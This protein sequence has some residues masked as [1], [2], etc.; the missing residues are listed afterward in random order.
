MNK[1]IRTKGSMSRNI[2]R[3]NKNGSYKLS[4]RVARTEAFLDGL[5]HEVSELV[6]SIKSLNMMMAEQAE[7]TDKKFDELSNK[8]SNIGR[9]PG[10]TLAAWAAVILAVVGLAGNGYVRDQQRLESDLKNTKEIVLQNAKAV[11]EAGRDVESAKRSIKE[12]DTKLQREVSLVNA[13]TKTEI[14]SLDEKLQIEMVGANEKLLT[15]ME[16]VK[17]ELK[18]SR[19]WRSAHDIRVRGLNESQNERLTVLERAVFKEHTDR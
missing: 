18:E 15:E 7:R 4:E 16:W 3:F 12:L 2:N 1:D 10:A 19:A 9:I 14:E 11:S 17:N 6:S 8:V 13:E 5:A